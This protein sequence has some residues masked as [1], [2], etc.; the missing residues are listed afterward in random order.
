MAS[1]SASAVSQQVFR[2]MTTRETFKS[3]KNVV[4][5]KIGLSFYLDVVILS[6]CGENTSFQCFNTVLLLLCNILMSTDLKDS[7]AHVKFILKLIRGNQ[8]GSNS[9]FKKI[10]T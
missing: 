6:T 9:A 2:S 5:V 3:Y 1:F 4:T 10:R 8:R 7:L